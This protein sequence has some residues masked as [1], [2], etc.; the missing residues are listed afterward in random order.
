MAAKELSTKKS[1]FQKFLDFVEKV[2]N[3]L[4][5]PVTLFVILS[6]IVIVIS[7]ILE[8]MGVAVTYE[9]SKTVDGVTK[10][11]KVSYSTEPYC[12]VEYFLVTGEHG[13]I[14]ELY[15]VTEVYYS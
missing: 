3:K 12:G 15:D 1:F 5:N 13:K 14:A 6:L 8:M 7:Q 2:G 4:P 9:A 10:I 11:E